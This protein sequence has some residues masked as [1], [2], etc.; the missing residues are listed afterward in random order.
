M[1]KSNNEIY[2]ILTKVFGL[3]VLINLSKALDCIP[4]DLLI[5]KLHAYGFSKKTVTFNNSYLKRRKQNVKIENFYS[6]FLTLLLG[7]PQGSILSPILL[8]LFVNDSPAILKNSELFNF[9][10]D[11]CISTT[12]KNMDNLIHTLV[13]ESKT[14]VEWFNQ[15]QNDSE[16]R[17]ISS[18]VAR[19]KK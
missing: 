15:K 9:A 7:V 17:Q 13:K 18:H 5:A 11:N 8:N 2:S 10:D 16:T 14:T 1:Y 6:D 19:E 3:A 12:S 4:H